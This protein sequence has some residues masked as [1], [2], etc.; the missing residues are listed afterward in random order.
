MIYYLLALSSARSS[1]PCVHL[2][3]HGRPQK[4][5]LSLLPHVDCED[6][7][8]PVCWLA[9]APLHP[10]QESSRQDSL[11]AGV[12][13]RMQSPILSAFVWA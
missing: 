13:L 1:P 7:G 2:S 5:E 6:S 4:G 9:Q 10:R 3:L 12:V 8:A 11:F